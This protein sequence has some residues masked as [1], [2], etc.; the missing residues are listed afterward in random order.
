MLYFERLLETF[1]TVFVGEIYGQPHLVDTKNI[2]G[3]ARLNIAYYTSF[4]DYL[5]V[6]T[7]TI[8]IF[9]AN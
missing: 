1:K 6:K 9:Y 7:H 2:N 4:I 5:K 8:K 3:G